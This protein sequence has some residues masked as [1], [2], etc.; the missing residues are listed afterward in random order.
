MIIFLMF[1]SS[2]HHLHVLILSCYSKVE[3]MKLHISELESNIKSTESELEKKDKEIYELKQMLDN[4][5][6]TE[7]E[8]VEF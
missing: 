7:S 5:H 1:Y 6:E 3:N 4:V 8:K 2:L